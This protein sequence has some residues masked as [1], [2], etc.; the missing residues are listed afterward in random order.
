[1]E[2]EERQGCWPKI[3]PPPP[4]DF[5]DVSFLMLRI[6]KK[7]LSSYFLNFFRSKDGL[8]ELVWQEDGTVT[9]KGMTMVTHVKIEIG[10]AAIK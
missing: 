4:L 1:M 3:P 7:L 10:A 9:F 5:R 2:K 6:K 8:F